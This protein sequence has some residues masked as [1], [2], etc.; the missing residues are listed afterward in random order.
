MAHFSFIGVRT[1]PMYMK[2]IFTLACAALFFVMSAFTNLSGLE[3][4][5]GALRKGNATELAK[6]VDDNIE[7]SLPDKSDNYSKAQAVMILQDFFANN[8]VK[9]FD[10]IHKGD[11]GGSQ[12]CI[13]TLQTRSGNYRTTVFMKTKNGKQLVKQ[14]TFRP[15]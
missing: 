14:I 4:V 5:I 11:R 6:Y 15:E 12:F 1:K 3:D 8:G 10:V 7:I 2:P 9:N 13:G